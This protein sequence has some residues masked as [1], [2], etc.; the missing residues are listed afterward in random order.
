[1]LILV[2]GAILGLLAER[3]GRASLE[4]LIG[5]ELAREAGHVAERMAEAVRIRNET[6]AGFARQEVMREIRFSDLD[7]RI[8]RALLTLPTDARSRSGY[9]VLDVDGAVVAATNPDWWRRTPDWAR[10]AT[11]DE[12]SGALGE[13]KVAAAEPLGVDARVNPDALVFS[14]P[15]HDP[16]QRANRIGTLVGCVDWSLLTQ[17][18]EV[19]RRD[20]GDRGIRAEVV[21]LD[22]R[23]RVLRRVGPAQG[24]DLVVPD[25]TLASLA[26]NPSLASAAQAA[27]SIVD[28][29]AGLIAGRADFGVGRARWSLLVLEP[30]SDA[31][32]PATQLRDRLFGTIAVALVGALVIASYGAGRVLRPLR[33]LTSAI[34]DVPRGAPAQAAVP[35]RSDDEV[36]TLAHTFNAMLRDLDRAQR[37]LVDAEKFALVGELAAGVAHEVRTSLGVLGSAA[38]ILG[39]LSEVSADPTAREMTEMVRA[40]VKRLGRVV[41]DLLTLD[42]QR[43]L[44]RHPVVLSEPLQAAVEFV[45]PQA[46]EKQVTIRFTPGPDAPIVL[47]DSEAITQV[48]VNLLSNAVASLE[49]GHSVELSIEPGRD[50]IVSFVVADDGLGIAPELRSRIFDPFVTGRAN[51]V[52]LG[53]T[54]VK[55]VVHAHHG[56]VELVD[57]HSPGAC[58]RVTLPVAGEA[59]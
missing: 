1:M 47:C 12:D 7:K 11:A 52:G 59:V 55:R 44:D 26:R 58:F 33:E 24:D 14:A 23:D 3:S 27:A 46:H 54:F 38:Q 5:R 35:V 22:E 36:G 48:C 30:L 28:R 19:V 45:S 49:P 53:L 43:P 56:H 40:E 20:L 13:A 39:R 42:H 10:S 8:A 29:D 16:D 15:I 18:A 37:Q 51:G 4:R 50:G 21:L 41:D 25:T 17:I 9:L 6:L 31:L 32:A 34:R 2:P 57:G